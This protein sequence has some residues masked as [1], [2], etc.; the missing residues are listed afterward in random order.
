MDCPVPP[1]QEVGR[2]G[3]TSF[4]S[5][6]YLIFTY[7]LCFLDNV[8]L[9]TLQYDFELVFAKNSHEFVHEYMKKPEF[10][11]LMRRLGAL[12]DGNQDQS[13]SF[14]PCYSSYLNILS[15]YFYPR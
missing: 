5:K 12:G 10:I 7:C 15:H 1:I 11:E 9:Y 3:L 8:L 4:K 14:L 2:R 6:L 13:K